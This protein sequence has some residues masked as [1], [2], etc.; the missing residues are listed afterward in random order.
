LRFRRGDLDGVFHVHGSYRDPHELV[1]DT[2][3]Y[4]EVTNSDEVQRVLK[5]FLEFNTIL[6]VG[7]GSGLEDPNFNALLRWASENAGVCDPPAA[8]FSLIC[9]TLS[10]P[11]I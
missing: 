2:T 10:E 5:N 11:W 1:L 8:A 9:V 6:F 4:Y 3:D 7:R